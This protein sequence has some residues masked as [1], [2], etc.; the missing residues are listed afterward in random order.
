M[1]LREDAWTQVDGDMNPFSHGGVFARLCGEDIELLAIE[2]VEDLVG[3]N[4]AQEVGYPFWTSEGYYDPSDLKWSDDAESTL[5]SSGEEDIGEAGWDSKDPVERAC[6]L[7]MY[8]CGKEPSGGGFSCDILHDQPFIGWGDDLR[9]IRLDALEIDD[10]FNLEIPHKVEVFRCAH[11]RD[12]KPVADSFIVGGR[13]RGTEWS[14]DLVLEAHEGRGGCEEN[15]LAGWRHNPYRVMLPDGS[16][17]TVEIFHT[18]HSHEHSS[19]A[20]YEAADIL[21]DMI[22]E[23][24]TLEDLDDDILALLKDAPT[25]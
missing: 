25:E 5:R 8:G 19:S 4:E 17:L 23:G 22:N 7:F 13:H 21:C 2:N 18:F 16:L 15:Y 10:E 14:H 1:K 3:R 20:L 9:D 12:N 24:T 6:R 11:M